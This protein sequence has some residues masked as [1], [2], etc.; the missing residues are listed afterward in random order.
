M[1]IGKVSLT[2]LSVTLTGSQISRMPGSMSCEVDN[3][4]LPL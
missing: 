1:S 2:T 4:T 3:P